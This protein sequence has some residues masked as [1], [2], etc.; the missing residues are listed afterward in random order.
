MAESGVSTSSIA[1]ICLDTTNCTVVA[2]DEGEE[3]QEEEQEQEG[4]VY[5]KTY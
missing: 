2:L 5:V 1:A 3:E 4:E